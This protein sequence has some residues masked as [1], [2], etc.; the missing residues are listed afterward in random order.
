MKEEWRAIPGFERYEVSDQGRVRSIWCRGRNRIKVLR[1]TPGTLGYLVV[2]LFREGSKPRTYKVHRLVLLAFSGPPPDGFEGAHL[3]GINT[4]NRLVN[5]RWVTPKENQGHRKIH[6]TGNV[7]RN[8]PMAKL[9]EEQVLEIRKA[10]GTHGV[11]GRAYG[12]AQSHVSLI[13]SKKT[14]RHI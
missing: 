9:T 7:G 2:N 8:H 5:L 10:E 11:I 12:I 4:D 13:K 3:N 1:L 14:W 6:G